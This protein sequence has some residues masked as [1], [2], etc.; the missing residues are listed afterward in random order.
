MIAPI[1]CS[2][3]PGVQVAARGILPAAAPGTMPRPFRIG[4]AA[5]P[6]RS[7]SR[8]VR[9]RRRQPLQHHRALAGGVPALETGAERS[10]E[11]ARQTARAPRPRPPPF[12][13]LRASGQRC[14]P[15]CAPPAS[16]DPLGEKRASRGSGIRDS[17]QPAACSERTSSARA[18]R[19]APCSCRP[20]WGSRGRSLCT[21][22]RRGRSPRAAAS[23]RRGPGDRRRPAAPPALL[24][25]AGHV[26]A[27]AERGGAVDGIGCRQR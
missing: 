19:R 26:L 27:E 16:P 25:A 13:L 24:E 12:D 9:P 10:G 15:R 5:D 7:P 4:G 22:T 11:I 17:G 21:I 3:T 20:G 23:A 14:R 1:A 18:P 2:R 6:A 8:P